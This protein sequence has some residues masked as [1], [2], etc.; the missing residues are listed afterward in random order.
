M[1]YSNVIL[2]CTSGETPPSAKENSQRSKDQTAL[3]YKHNSV[4]NE[5]A[6]ICYQCPRVGQL[7]GFTMSVFSQ[8]KLNKHLLGWACEHLLCSAPLLSTSLPI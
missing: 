3:Y 5:T 1:Y 8:S 4:Y 7:G 2:Y 6:C